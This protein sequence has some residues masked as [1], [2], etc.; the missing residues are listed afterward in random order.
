MVVV[1]APPPWVQWH[2][3]NVVELV[4][5]S[6]QKATP[7]VTQ[8]GGTTKMAHELPPL[9][10]AYDALEPYYDKE[11]VTLHHDKHHQTYVNGL[12]AAE[13]KVRGMIESGNYAGAHAAANDQAFHG[14]GHILHTIFWN[15]M[16]PGGGGIPT[17][18]LVDAINKTFGSMEN[19]TSLFL[20]TA[21]AIQGSGWAILAYRQTDDSLV[22]LGAEKHE[23]LTQWGVQPLLVLD[24]WE[25]AYYLKYQNRRPEWT[26]AFMDNL[27]NWDDVASRY[28]ESKSKV[29][30]ST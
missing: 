21:N 29:G 14:S 1:E 20:S 12:N 9:P 26:K 27:V 5:A 6:R 25:H 10:Y 3:P 30:T 17:G 24:V 4:L 13:E 28:A 16:K 2:R 23:N 11:T 18:E 7:T 22:I 8:L 19:F 15:N